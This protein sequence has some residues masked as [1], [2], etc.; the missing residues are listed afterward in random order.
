MLRK[1]GK[2]L[3]AV[4]TSPLSLIAIFTV[5]LRFN[6]EELDLPHLFKL[7]YNPKVQGNHRL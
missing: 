7:R 5:E 1:I 3:G 4:P 6:L 2:A